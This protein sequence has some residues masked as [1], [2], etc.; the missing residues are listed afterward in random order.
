MSDAV[1]VANVTQLVVKNCTV[2]L[3]GCDEEVSGHERM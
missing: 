1:T 3:K 2:D